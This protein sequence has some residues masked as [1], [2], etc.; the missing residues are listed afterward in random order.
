M[1]ESKIPDH[2]SNPKIYDSSGSRK[3]KLSKANF[4]HSRHESPQSKIEKTGK[5]ST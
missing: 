5:E 1:S 4:S 2:S 3:S